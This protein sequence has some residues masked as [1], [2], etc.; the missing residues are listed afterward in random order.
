MVKDSSSETDGE[1]SQAPSLVL[2]PSAK[3]EA[4]LSGAA[5]GTLVSLTKYY[6]LGGL[7]RTNIYFSVLVLRSLR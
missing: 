3:A 1:N 4:R 6:T 5:Q 2:T 7:E